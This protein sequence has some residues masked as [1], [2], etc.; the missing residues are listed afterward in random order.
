MIK[1]ISRKGN[2]EITEHEVW[3]NNGETVL[4][5][6]LSSNDKAGIIDFLSS[7]SEETRH[8]YV[9]DDYGEKTADSLC[10]SVGKAGKMHFVVVNNSSEIIALVKFSLDLPDVD[11]SRYL[12]YG[13]SFDPGSVT[14]CGTCITD[15]YQNL[16]LGGIT[17]QQ[18]IDASRY[19]GQRMII[20]S[21]G[22]YANN[23]RAI[24]MCQKHGFRIA[25]RFTDMYG[26]VHVDMFRDI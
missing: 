13:V 9:L 8:F 15:K 6:P 7:L 23:Q 26:H 19:L 11:K 17:L 1:E 21:G 14:R 20:L 2:F 5:R 3:L 18:I 25:G 12:K 22:I 10:K 16:G 4:I 24:H